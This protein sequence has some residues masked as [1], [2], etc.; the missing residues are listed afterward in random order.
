MFNKTNIYVNNRVKFQIAGINESEDRE[1]WSFTQS[2]ITIMKVVQ[3]LLCEFGSGVPSFSLQFHFEPKKT[4]AKYIKKE[5]TNEDFV[6][7]RRNPRT[8]RYRGMG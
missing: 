6:K 2:H 1:V 5:T 4:L 8:I 3:F 7:Q